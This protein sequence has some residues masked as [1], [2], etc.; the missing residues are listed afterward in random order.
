MRRQGLSTAY[1]EN[2]FKGD[3]DPWQRLRENDINSQMVQFENP[4]GKGPA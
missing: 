1:F 3:Q 2:I 4:H